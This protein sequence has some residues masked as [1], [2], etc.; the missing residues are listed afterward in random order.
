VEHAGH[1]P[2]CNFFRNF[3][4][5][6]VFNGR[7]KR[8]VSVLAALSAAAILVPAA[9]SAQ[10]IQVGV[11]ATPLIAP[12]CPANA[13]GSACKIVLTQVTAYETKRDGV[14][15]P[16][17]IK[18]SGMISSFSLG[19]T[20]TST[21]T[22]SDLTYLDKLYGGPPEAQLTILRRTGASAHPAFRVAAQS[23]IF[24]VRGELGQVAEFP[25]VAP[26]PVVRGEVVAITIP[27]WAPVL[28]FELA[29]SKFSYAQSRSN[30][31]VSSTST[32]TGTTTTTA[33]TPTT[34]GSA[35]SSCSRPAGA[36]LAQ[37]T[38]G[39]LSNYSCTFPGT[40]VEYSALEVTTPAGFY[41]ADRRRVG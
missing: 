30:L 26:L 11:T 36:N 33:T 35:V 41:A 31:K 3:Y 8:L 22:A 6:L 37:I 32:T 25:L 5:G 40:R 1:G 17:T 38:I 16:D 24:R 39:A 9:A 19:L 23:P 10:E 15:N 21:I 14:A 2:A 29:P 18:K 27:T 20:G 7:M 28:S 13:T 34:T 4:A 12:T